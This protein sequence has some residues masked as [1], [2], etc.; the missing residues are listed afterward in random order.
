MRKNY[1][2][3]IKGLLKDAADISQAMDAAMNPSLDPSSTT[4]VA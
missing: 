1:T 2:N 4:T 3:G